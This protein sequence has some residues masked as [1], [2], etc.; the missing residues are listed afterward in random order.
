[1]K[2]KLYL[3][4]LSSIAVRITVIAG[5]CY[6][7]TATISA[8]NSGYSDL[9]GRAVREATG[10]GTGLGAL[11]G[12]GAGV[13]AARN[14]SDSQRIAAGLA[15]ALIGSQV[16]KGIGRKTGEKQ[17]SKTR[18]SFVERSRAEARLRSARQYNDK[19]SDYNQSLQN[20]IA[21]LKSS[22]SKLGARTA[23]SQAKRKQSEAA[24]QSSSLQSYAKTLPPQE[25][26]QVSAAVSEI[27]ESSAVTGSLIAELIKIEH[28]VY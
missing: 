5:L 27:Q 10:V 16:G 3:K 4:S 22:K 24:K 15:G 28:S 26:S 19:L 14:G 8:Q 2:K 20:R 25:S 18:H 17:V 21:Q 11:L 1:M 12:A 7:G 23:I 6:S 13:L 9:E